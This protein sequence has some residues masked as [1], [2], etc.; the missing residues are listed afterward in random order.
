MHV[1]VN[2]VYM[3]GKQNLNG[4]NKI[5]RMFAKENIWDGEKKDHEQKEKK[6]NK[7]LVNT[8]FVP[9]S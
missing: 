7:N 3:M 4:I 5:N 8:Y 2:C 6:W 1:F 9:T